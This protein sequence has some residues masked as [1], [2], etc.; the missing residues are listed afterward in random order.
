MDIHFHSVYY[1]QA[2]PLYELHTN[3][4][5]FI[6]RNLATS[7]RTF[8]FQV[9]CLKSNTALPFIK[10][11]FFFSVAVTY[12]STHQHLCSITHKYVYMIREYY[13]LLYIYI[14]L[15]CRIQYQMTCPQPTCCTVLYRMRKTMIIQLGQPVSWKSE[16]V[17]S[18]S[19]HWC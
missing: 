12:A 8:S 4:V 15:Y 13:L 18:W 17:K 9:I 7:I 1:Q 3:V 6:S 11:R 19:D 2:F 5:R 16:K 14:K 10:T